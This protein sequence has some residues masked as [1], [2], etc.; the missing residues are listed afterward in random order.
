MAFS[1]TPALATAYRAFIFTY[2]DD[3]KKPKSSV[4][5]SNDMYHNHSW[6]Q[7]AVY[8]WPDLLE[9]RLSFQ[10]LQMPDYVEQLIKFFNGDSLSSSSTDSRVYVEC[11]LY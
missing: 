6:H 1:L 2:K 8:Q 5:H 3:I 4:R 7:L 10:S 9:L 11:L